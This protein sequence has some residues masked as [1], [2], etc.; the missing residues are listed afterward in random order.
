MNHIRRNRERTI[1]EQDV[2]TKKNILRLEKQQNE[3]D[4]KQKREISELTT[5]QENAAKQVS[6]FPFTQI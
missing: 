3:E 1:K 6:C 4:Q 2:E 5:E